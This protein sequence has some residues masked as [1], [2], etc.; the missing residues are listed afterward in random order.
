MGICYE[1]NTPGWKYEP[2]SKI[3]IPICGDGVKNGNEQCDDGNLIK[4]DGC[5]D[6]CEFQCHEA[7]LNCE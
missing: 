7:C 3:C 4:N 5:S 6:I 2:N 1:C